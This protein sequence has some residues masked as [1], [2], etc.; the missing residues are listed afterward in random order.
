MAGKLSPPRPSFPLLPPQSNKTN[1]SRPL[2][3]PAVALTIAFDSNNTNI[4]EYYE[5]G[6]SAKSLARLSKHVRIV[7]Y[8]NCIYV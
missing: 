7:R 4:H 2:S 3:R 1:V 5:V 6:I 8:L